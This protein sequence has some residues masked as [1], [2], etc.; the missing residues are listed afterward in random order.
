MHVFIT[1]VTGFVGSA[2]AQRLLDCGYTVTG[3][4]RSPE[5][6]AIQHPQF[7]YL[8]ADTTRQ[9]PWQDAVGEA[10]AVINLAGTSI[11]HR[12]T[13]SSKDNMR[14][15][16]IQTTRN[17]VEALPSGKSVTFCSASGVGFYGSRGGDI[18][19][20]REPSG[21]DFLAKMSVDWELEAGRASDKGARVAVMRFGVVLGRHGGALAKMLPAFKSFVGGPIGPGTQWFSWIHLDDIVGAVLFAFEHD[22]VEGPVNFCAPNPVRNRDLAKAIGEVLRRP[23]FLSAPAFA[24]R[25][26]LGEF[27]SVLLDSQRAIPGK[28]LDC[29]YDFRYAHIRDAV[30]ASVA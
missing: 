14:S 15:S 8:S 2:L 21:E 23:A 27:G 7:R 12:W 4:G 19:T 5:H 28:L 16:R 30:A 26:A 10:Q 3:V 1:G 17:V 20:E 18:L 9:G 24:V 6:T 25:L 29:G 11:F 13:D 22:S